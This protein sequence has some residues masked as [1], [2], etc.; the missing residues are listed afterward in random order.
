MPRNGFST[1]Y[2]LDR[3]KCVRISGQLFAVHC[4]KGHSVQ[5]LK[6]WPLTGKTKQTSLN[7]HPQM[8]V[9]VLM[10]LC[11]DVQGA[12]VLMSGLDLERLCLAALQLA[13]RRSCLLSSSVSCLFDGVWCRVSV[14]CYFQSAR[15]LGRVDS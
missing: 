13:S 2:Q 11:P 9:Y 5:L 1:G 6:W 12:Y 15:P 7:Y 4:A 8:R 10:P 14:A 3:L